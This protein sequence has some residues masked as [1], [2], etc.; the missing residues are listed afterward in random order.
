MKIYTIGFT[1][2]SAENFFKRVKYSGTRK[3]ID[4]RLNNI[5]QL[6]GFAKRDDLRFFSKTIANVDYQHLPNLAPNQDMLDRYKKERGPWVDYARS[7]LKLMSD[8][9]IENIPKEDIDGTCFLCS[10]DKPHNCHRRLV[11]EYLQDAWGDVEI[12]HL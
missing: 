8:R 6:S 9:Q 12:L 3:I 7:F 2:T 1:K 5:S 4:V 10:E 11:A